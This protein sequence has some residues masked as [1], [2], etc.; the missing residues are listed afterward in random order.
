MTEFKFE[1]YE[2]AKHQLAIILHKYNCNEEDVELVM[3]ACKHIF[4]GNLKEAVEEKL[5]EMLKR[6]DADEWVNPHDE[7][8]I[9]ALKWFQELLEC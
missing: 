2:D 1:S 7:G 3:D 9:E 5:K 4:R 6:D 8:I